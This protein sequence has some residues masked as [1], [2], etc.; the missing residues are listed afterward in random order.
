MYLN[1]KFAINYSSDFCME[2]KYGMIC[3]YKQ[4]PNNLFMESLRGHH[5]DRAF[6]EA[7]KKEETWVSPSVAMIDRKYNWM[8]PCSPSRTTG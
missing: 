6:E 3:G 4:E 2:E 7:I 8:G 1:N 5:K